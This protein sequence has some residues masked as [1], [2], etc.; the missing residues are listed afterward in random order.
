MD[1]APLGFSPRP[2]AE[3]DI[4]LSSY[5]ESNHDTDCTKVVLYL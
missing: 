5:A 4:Q 1:P 3:R 2:F